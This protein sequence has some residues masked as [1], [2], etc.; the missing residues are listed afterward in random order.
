MTLTL[1][2]KMTYQGAKRNTTQSIDKLNTQ[3]YKQITTLT[4]IFSIVA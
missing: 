1:T 2:S 3:T 4:T